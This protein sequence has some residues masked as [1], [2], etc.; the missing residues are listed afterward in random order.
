MAGVEGQAEAGDGL[1]ELERD[2]GVGGQGLG[3]GEQGQDQAPR[4]AVPTSDESRLI[5]SSSGVPSGRGGAWSARRRSAAWPGGT[6]LEPAAMQPDRSSRPGRSRGGAT[7]GSGSGRGGA[8]AWPPR[9]RRPPPTAAG[10]GRPRRWPARTCR[11]PAPRSGEGPSPAA[12]SRSRV[13]CRRRTPDPSSPSSSDACRPAS[14]L[15]TGRDRA[16]RP[17]SD[18]SENRSSA[19][20]RSYRSL[21]SGDRAE[22]AAGPAAPGLASGELRRTGPSGSRPGRW[23]GAPS[24]SSDSRANSA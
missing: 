24:A 20:D 9:D 14:G 2:L 17:P 16:A 1:A 23:D 18:S 19:G 7:R 12:P 4:M 11:T 5:S 6:G 13:C 22:A 21:R 3:V 15:R 8:V 10:A